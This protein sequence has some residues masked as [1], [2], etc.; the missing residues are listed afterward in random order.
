MR[1]CKP[2]RAIL[3]CPSLHECVCVCVGMCVCMCV[4]WRQRSTNRRDLLK[5][6]RCPESE[7]GCRE[8]SGGR[9]HLTGHFRGLGNGL[10]HVAVGCAIHRVCVGAAALVLHRVAA[11]A[12]ALVGV[13]A[14]AVSLAGVGAGAVA[15]KGRDAGARGGAGADQAGHAGRRH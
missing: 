1:F 7:G 3:S 9:G 12:A 6:F 5:R 15:F 10:V 13:R 11:A 8:R 2:R 14:G 4:S